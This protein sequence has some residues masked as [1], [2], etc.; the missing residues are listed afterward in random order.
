MDAFRAML[1]NWESRSQES[2]E[3]V[4]YSLSLHKRDLV[5]IKAFAQAYGLDEA[6][7]TQSLI[8]CALEQAEQAMPYVK[9]S[10]IIRIEEGEEI[11]ADAGK[12]PAFVKAEQAISRALEVNSPSS[13]S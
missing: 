10:E 11:Y 7:I 8:H 13:S 3:R 4:E 1:D 9:G 6:T 12:T 5:K 2:S